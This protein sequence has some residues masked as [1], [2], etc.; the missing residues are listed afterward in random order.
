MGLFEQL[1]QELNQSAQMEL[2]IDENN[3][4][5]LKIKNKFALQMEVYKKTGED[6]VIACVLGE[7]P[8]G[9]YREMLLQE[10]LVSNGEPHPR[11]GIFAYSKDHNQ[12]ILYEILKMSQL[13]GSSLHDYIKVLSQKAETWYDALERQDIPQISKQGP[14]GSSETIFGMKL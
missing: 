7:V 6:L 3:C 2:S 14:S 1:I 9:K 5:R 10:A 13:T 8:P 12:L 11:Y 4:C